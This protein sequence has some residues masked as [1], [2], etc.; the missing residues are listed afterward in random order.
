MAWYEWLAVQ[1]AIELTRKDSDLL[2][3]L[4]AGRA[5]Q[6]SVLDGLLDLAGM[7]VDGLAGAAGLRSLPG[8]IAVLAT[9]GGSS[10]AERIGG[11][12]CDFA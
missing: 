1:K 5:R 2:K 11:Q 9:K 12:G 8:D 7:V 10:V 3:K 6:V 4:F